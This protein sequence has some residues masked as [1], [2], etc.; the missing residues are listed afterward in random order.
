V[1]DAAAIAK[2][3]PE[4]LAEVRDGKVSLAQAK[5][6]LGLAPKPDEEPWCIEHDIA[7]FHALRDK[8][9]DRWT[10]WREQTAMRD[11]FRV[12][13]NDAV[14]MTIEGL[15]AD[16]ARAAAEKAEKAKVEEAAK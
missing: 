14:G 11:C 10:G 16:R 6:D 5:R 3:S 8:L 13:A 15:A 7:K 9:K 1:Q 12:M 2:A 4:K